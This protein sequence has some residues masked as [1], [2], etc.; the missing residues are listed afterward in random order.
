M[1]L[2]STSQ[3]STVCVCTC[4]C[5]SVSADCLLPTTEFYGICTDIRSGYPGLVYVL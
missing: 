1:R 3:C 2:S 4:V 5:V